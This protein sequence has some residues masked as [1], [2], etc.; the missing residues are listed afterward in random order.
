MIR[1][2]YFPRSRA[3][4]VLWTCEELGL[5][6]EAVPITRELKQEPEHLIRHP[7]GRVPVA[8]LSDGTHLFESAAICLYLA[9][10]Q[11]Q[12]LPP[13]GSFERGLVY[14]WLFFAM[15]EMEPPIFQAQAAR[16]TGGDDRS[17]FDRITRAARAIARSLDASQWLVA[18]TFSVADIVAVRVLGVAVDGDLLGDDLSQLRD[19]VRRGRDRPAYQRALAVADQVWRER[20][21]REA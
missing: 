16:R 2:Y 5:S 13:A 12:L 6:Y 18:D 11:G 4:R 3:Q 10:S 19:Y 20:P 9:E 21:M 1:V 8:E 17:A 7:L 14:Q 15:T